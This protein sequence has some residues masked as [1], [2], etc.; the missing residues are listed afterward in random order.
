MAFIESP[1]GHL[2]VGLWWTCPPQEEPGPSDYEASPSSE[3]LTLMIW[4]ESAVTLPLPAHGEPLKVQNK[5]S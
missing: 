2:A 4:L 5:L 3:G 1:D